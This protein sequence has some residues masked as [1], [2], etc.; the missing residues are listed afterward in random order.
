[1]IQ[2]QKRNRP[3]IV[4]G[5]VLLFLGIKV[6][7]LNSSFE[8]VLEQERWVA[9]TYEILNE[10]DLTIS[11]AKDAETAVRGYLLT[12]QED[13]LDLYKQGITNALSHLQKV[14]YLTRDN[15]EQSDASLVIRENL[16]KRFAMLESLK[17]DYMAKGKFVP[18]NAGVTGGKTLM[19]VLR[20]QVEGMKNKEKALLEARSLGVQQS[21]NLFSWILYLSNF[22]LSL[23][24]IFA[25]VQIA[26]NIGKS[27]DEAAEKTLEAHQKNLVASYAQSITGDISLTIAAEKTLHSLSENLQTL[28]GKLYILDKGRLTLVASLGTASLPSDSKYANES[29]VRTAF[30]KNQVWQIQDIPSDYWK[31]SSGLGETLPR[32]VVF[33]PIA[34]QGYQIGIIELASFKNLDKNQL[35]FVS[36]MIE[37]IGIGI[38][39]AES[40]SQLQALLKT[41]Q[42]Q[43]EELQAQQEELRA[44]NEELEQQARALESQQQA[45]NIK[46]KELETTQGQLEIRARDLERSTQYKSEFLA[47]MSHELRTPLNGLL[48]LSTLLM[49]NKEKNLTDQQRKFAKSIHS[50]GNDLLV[51]INDILDL[52]KIEARKLTLKAEKFTLGD[53][54]DA[55]KVTFEPQTAAKSLALK[56]DL[57]ANLRDFNLYTDRQRLDQVLRNFISNAIKFTAEGSITASAEVSNHDD[58]IKIHVKDTGI[59]IPANKQQLIFD[60]FEQADSS[61]SRQYGGTGLGLTISRELAHLLGGSISLVSEEGKGSTFTIAIPSHLPNAAEHTAEEKPKLTKASYRT[62]DDENVVSQKGS[63]ADE[64]KRAVKL[65]LKDIDSEK[66]ILIV[67]DDDNFRLSVVEAARSYGFQTIEAY[68]GEV[69]LG[70]LKSHVPSA[71]LL[72]IKLP[73]I[74]GLGILEMIKQM[75]HLRHIP[76]HMI[77]ALEY[78]QD[79]LR[80]GALGYLTKPVTIDK[81]RSALGRIE[82]VIS[83]KVRRVLLVE[84]DQTQSLAISEL[85]AGSDIEVIS[86]HTGNDAIEKVKSDSYDCIIL[87]LTLPDV[88]G[89]D[90]LTDLRKLEI[91]LPPIV[92]Y[93]GKDLSESEDQ[94]LR[95]FSESIIIKG[96]RS[97][98][99]LLDEVNLFLHRVESLLPDSTREMLSQLRSQEKTFEGKKVLVVDDDIRNI[100]ALTSA[101]ESKGLQ[102]ATARDGLE[103]LE[104]IESH[105]D[106]DIILMDIMMPRMDGYEAIRHIRKNPDA[107][108]NKLPIVALTAKAMKEDHERCIEA[109]A[110]DYLPKPINLENLMTIL[111]VWLTPK[112][113]FS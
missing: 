98:E 23:I 33:I 111:K 59:G 11:G 79:A 89:V 62:D 68:D 40:R 42:Q 10:L 84:D 73:G 110:S 21:K 102:I 80:M 70:I 50:A 6:S 49:E 87:D 81:V 105:K 76:V 25:F 17:N 71:I 66:T 103:A 56:M 41:T 9:H 30:E 44:S 39:A 12:G 58:L 55:M 106:I 74:S 18:N 45:L 104:I 35:N 75:P 99:R 82:K 36:S 46:N 97:P 48:I 83:N 77:S 91:A 8:Q 31:I 92:I 15:Q 54:F 13:H 29:L 14:T 112:G 65:A 94:Y 20:S 1:M 19:D 86:A 47:K 101:L 4:L 52:S 96:A 26:K 60:A 28:A 34:F 100:F 27:E 64:V 78:Q 22:I 61:V 93:T 95:K 37:T 63:S 38:N 3:L 57:P 24:L 43:S 109:G 7:I 2:I 85:I 88:T 51:L 32:S 69:A 5:A 67:E 113:L 16:E 72:D 107:R 90:L 108:I 53:L